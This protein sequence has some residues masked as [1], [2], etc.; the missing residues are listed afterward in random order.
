MTSK[1]TPDDFF[2]KYAPSL[3]EQWFSLGYACMFFNINPN[4]LDVLMEDADVRFSK[5]VDGVM[6][7]NGDAMQKL[8]NTYNALASEINSVTESVVNN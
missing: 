5:V 1:K 3:D 7:L 4:Q 2:A 8:T 6:Y